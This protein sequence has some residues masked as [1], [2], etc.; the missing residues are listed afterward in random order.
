[1][2]PEISTLV[3]HTGGIGDFLLTC[4]SILQL[5]KEG[6]VDL[7]GSPTR[8]ALA[9]EGGIA[10]AAYDIDSLK[11]H[12]LLS[13]PSDDLKTFLKQY[14]R[15]VVW[16]RDDD[17][18]IQKNLDTIGIPQ[19]HVYPGLPPE[20]WQRHATEYFQEALGLPIDPTPLHLNI[21]PA[22]DRHDII[23]HPGSGDPD[24]NWSLERFL[25][26]GLLVGSIDHE[27]LWCLGPAEI[28]SKNQDFAVLPENKILQIDSLVELA[29]HLA[30]TD[31][32]FGNDSGITHLAAAVG[33]PTIALFGP[34][35]PD[36]WAPRG[37]DVRIMD[38]TGLEFSKLLNEIAER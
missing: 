3:V 6:S 2:A 18:A 10:R 25:E 24:K 17:G 9:V 37:P 12:S 13:E 5:A 29:S 36:V 26:L 7:L 23:I 32:Y 30:A 33:C 22:T 38:I 28:E 14:D 31:L 15:V 27:I 4:P 34:T 1:M 11:F 35:N 21:A 20:D 8:M 19:V 16:M